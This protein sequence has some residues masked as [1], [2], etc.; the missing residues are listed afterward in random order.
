MQVKNDVPAAPHE[1]ALNRMHKQIGV[2]HESIRD[3][4]S[5]PKPIRGRIGASLGLIKGFIKSIRHAVGLHVEQEIHNARTEERKAAQDTISGIHRSYQAEISA[6]KGRLNR[7]HQGVVA[8]KDE[9]IRF[10]KDE[11]EGERGNHE[12]TRREL[13]TANRRIE[14]LEIQEPELGSIAAKQL[15]KEYGIVNVDNLKVPLAGKFIPASSHEDIWAAVHALRRTGRK[16]GFLDVFKLPNGQ[17]KEVLAALAH[18]GNHSPI[19]K[20]GG[21]VIHVND[22]TPPVAKKVRGLLEGELKAG[23]KLDQ[24]TVF[25]RNIHPDEIQVKPAI[26]K[27]GTWLAAGAAIAATLGGTA[28]FKNWGSKAPAPNTPKEVI[29]SINDIKDS[30]LYSVAQKA[31]APVRPDAGVDDVAITA[32]LMRHELENLQ[33]TIMNDRNKSRFV[34]L[35]DLALDVHGRMAR[36][37]QEATD[38][39]KITYT[40]VSGKSGPQAMTTETLRKVIYPGMQLPREKWKQMD[41]T[42]QRHMRPTWKAFKGFGRGQR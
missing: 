34:D 32:T 7:E 15:R 6:I 9:S 20:I 13:Q 31:I 39:G 42:Y 14:Q 24:V 4:E 41:S 22:L 5:I 10:H 25:R 2:L 8:S 35:K 12:K 1:E 16:T 36:V 30:E 28:I 18:N 26:K 38:A 11:L 21:E 33:Q 29:R 27:W 23:T 40:G 37:R 17:D 3:E 19:V